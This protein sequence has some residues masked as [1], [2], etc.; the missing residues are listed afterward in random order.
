MWVHEHLCEPKLSVF[1]YVT[2]G[3]ATCIATGTVMGIGARLVLKQ[4]WGPG[5]SVC[6]CEAM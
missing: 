1:L 2:V 5:L 4:N 6:T 3:M